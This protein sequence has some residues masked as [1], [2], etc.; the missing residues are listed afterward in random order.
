MNRFV[1]IGNG[2]D[3]AHGLKTKYEHFIIDLINTAIIEYNRKGSLGILEYNELF[4]LDAKPNHE[5]INTFKKLSDLLNNDHFNIS[6]NFSFKA[7]RIISTISSKPYSLIIKSKLFEVLLKQEKWTDIEKAYFDTLIEVYEFHRKE[8]VNSLELKKLNEDFELIKKYLFKYLQ[9]QEKLK[10]I[11]NHQLYYLINDI[12]TSNDW[13]INYP[14]KI[15][16][17]FLNKFDKKNIEDLFLINFNYTNILEDN[18]SNGKLTYHIHGKI[19][20]SD[21]II[22]GYGD[23]NNEYYKRLEEL[24]NEDVLKHFKSHYY[25]HEKNIYQQLFFQLD[26]KEFDVVVIG[27]SLGL[28]DKLLLESIFEHKKC[29]AIHLTHTGGDSH[30][31]KRIALSRHFNDKKLFREKLMNENDCLKITKNEVL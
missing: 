3:L 26:Q 10:F 2:F 25:H 23:E 28:S 30:F 9:D 24:G 14:N 29:E 16:E 20:D 5:P 1:I 19:L 11:T 4:E 7:E 6:N 22:F 17:N 31:R 18:Y 27:H 15:K 13:L 8:I 21:S 12:L